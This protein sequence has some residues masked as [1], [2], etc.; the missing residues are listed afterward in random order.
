MRSRWPSSRT[1]RRGGGARRRF[2]GAVGGSRSGVLGQDGAGRRRSAHG[3]VADRSVADGASGAWDRF[4]PCIREAPGRWARGLSS[5]SSGSSSVQ[6]G[7]VEWPRRHRAGVV[8]CAG[9]QHPSGQSRSAWLPVLV[10]G[11]LDR[12]EGPSLLVRP[13]PVEVPCPN[14]YTRLVLHI[15]MIFE[16]YICGFAPGSKGAATST[17]WGYLGCRGDLGECPV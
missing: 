5:A 6:V 12:G 11:S 17:G 7:A 4:D 13:W 2:A 3:S 15:V 8:R 9:P 16:R 10:P 1:L 14:S